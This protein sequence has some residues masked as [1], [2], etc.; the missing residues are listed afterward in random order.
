MSKFL[1]FSF[2]LL[3]IN[4]S[5]LSQPTDSLFYGNTPVLHENPYGWGY[6]A[7]TNHYGD[8]GKYQRFDVYDDIYILG[9]K[10]Y[11]GYLSIVDSPD[12][13]T[14]VVRDVGL[15]GQPADVI[16]SKV[17][18]TDMITIGTGGIYVEFNNA[19]HV[20]GSGFVPDTVFIG[21]EWA[22]TGNDT[23]AVFAD[24]D[25]EGQNENRAWERFSDGVFN[26]FLPLVFFPDFSWDIDVDLWIKAFYTTIPPS[27]INDKITSVSEY[28][29]NQN[30]PNPFNP[31]TTIGFSLPVRSNVLLKIF[32]LLGNEISTLVNGIKEAGN[33]NAVFDGSDLTAGVYFY[34]LSAESLS[35]EHTISFKNTKKIIL[36]K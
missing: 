12:Q 28:S 36:V 23:F 26:D 11:F 7:G 5:S 4:Y 20:P 31:T 19:I 25:G 6:I 35:P 24:A 9:A 17:I 16:E 13:L 14:I 33:H 8:I 27:N 22:T 32:D 29:L 30:Y 18:T 1:L 10:L 34:K 2:Y 15:Q 3:L 21:F